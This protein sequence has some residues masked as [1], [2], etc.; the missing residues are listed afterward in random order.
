LEP[1]SS[2]AF[3]QALNILIFVSNWVL[4]DLQILLSLQKA[5]VAFCISFATYLVCWYTSIIF[6]VATQ[7][8][9]ELKL[10]EDL[11]TQLHK[12]NCFSIDSHLLSFSKINPQIGFQGFFLQICAILLRISEGV[13]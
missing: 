2:T 8:H 10:M 12:M 3:T 9:T 6:S 13:G 11:F 1:H 5:A 4:L 7:V